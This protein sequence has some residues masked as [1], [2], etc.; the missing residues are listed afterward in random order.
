[1]GD[2]AELGKAFVAAFKRQYFDL[3][4]AALEQGIQEGLAPAVAVSRPVLTAR[5]ASAG[6]ARA[7]RTV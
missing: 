1:M 4:P 2:R 7:Y 6:T 5:S 3:A